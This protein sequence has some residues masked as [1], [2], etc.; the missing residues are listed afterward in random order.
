MWESL[1][2][3]ALCLSPRNVAFGEME[4]G[5]G[6]GVLEQQ[7]GGEAGQEE[8]GTPWKQ[9]SSREEGTE[10]WLMWGVV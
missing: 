6:E 9:G 1:V 10:A 3:F 8:E 2:V 4:A 7:V 5:E